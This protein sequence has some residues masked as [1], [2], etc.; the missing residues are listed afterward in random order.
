MLYIVYNSCQPNTAP[1]NRLLSFL[2]GFSE[3][4]TQVEVVF[5]E[6]DSNYNKVTEYLPNIYFNYMWDRLRK[7]I[8]LLKN[9]QAF[10]GDGSSPRIL[11]PVIK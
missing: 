11:K 6:P 9:L 3:L 8:D 10:I 2:R 4:G 7:K 5:L 1:T